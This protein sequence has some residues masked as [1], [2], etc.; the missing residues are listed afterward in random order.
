MR[1]LV[2]ITMISGHVGSVNYIRNLWILV[3]YYA[4]EFLFGIVL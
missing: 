1:K 4:A 2:T 3:K